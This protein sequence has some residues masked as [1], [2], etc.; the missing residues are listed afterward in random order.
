MLR[1]RQWYGAMSMM[2]G[3]SFHDDVQK[4]D[5]MMSL[6]KLEVAM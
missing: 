2:A 3:F 1:T 6:M 5:I 4:K